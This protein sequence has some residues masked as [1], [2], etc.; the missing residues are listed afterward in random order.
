M[1]VAPRH[2]AAAALCGH[3]S[4]LC[5]WVAWATVLAPPRHAPTSVMLIG[6]TLPLLPWLRGLLYDRRSTYV[7]LGLVSLGY[8][9]HGIGAA[10]DPENRIPAL[11]EV[12]FSLILFI[13]CLLRLK[14]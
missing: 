13:A 9:I 6:G 3:L 10:T 5:L 7:W 8:F 4:L 11:L 12:A 1:T 2:A 14:R